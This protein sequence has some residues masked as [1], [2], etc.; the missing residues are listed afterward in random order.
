MSTF[1]VLGL[2]DLGVDFLF[3]LTDLDGM[4]FPGGFGCI[5]SSYILL[6]VEHT[7]NFFVDD[8]VECKVLEDVHKLKFGVFVVRL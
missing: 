1:V 6:D 8:H 4:R 2:L 3:Q 7:L 5:D